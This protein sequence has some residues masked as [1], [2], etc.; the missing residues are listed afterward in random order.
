MPR[1]SYF[2]KSLFAAAL[3]SLAVF[4][5][6]MALLNG[7]IPFTPLVIF[8]AL[9][10]LPIIGL[11]LLGTRASYTHSRPSMPYVVPVIVPQPSCQPRFTPHYRRTH[12]HPNNQFFGPAPAFYENNH[13]HRNGHRN[14]HEHGHPSRR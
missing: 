2:R 8:A 5:G 11:Y 14:D 1:P 10:T 3:F 9:V 12:E 13:G 6:T 7:V 4:V